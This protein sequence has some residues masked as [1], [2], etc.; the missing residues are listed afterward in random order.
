MQFALFY[1]HLK[2]AHTSNSFSPHQRIMEANST[3]TN[4]FVYTV[5]DVNKF[6][7]HAILPYRWEG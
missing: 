3:F 4:V 6:V 1:T 7:P 2:S 5:T